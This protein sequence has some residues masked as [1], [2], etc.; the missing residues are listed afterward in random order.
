MCV[1]VCVDTEVLVDIDNKPSSLV[2]WEW[3][4]QHRQK[5]CACVRSA[6]TVCNS[7]GGGVAACAGILIRSWGVIMEVCGWQPG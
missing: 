4:I 5:E 3:V 2:C 1:P 6:L 7:D